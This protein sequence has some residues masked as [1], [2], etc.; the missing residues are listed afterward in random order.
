MGKQSP[1]EK[2]LIFDVEKMK[3]KKKEQYDYYGKEVKT[4]LEFL[5]HI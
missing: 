2:N 1:T 3:K 5:T 4:L